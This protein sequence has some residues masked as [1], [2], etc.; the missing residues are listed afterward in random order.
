[1]TRSP[2]TVAASTRRRRLG[3]GIALLGSALAATWYGWQTWSMPAPPP[4]DLTGVDPE[5][6]QA[7][8][9]AVAEVRQTP[10]DAL[11]WGRLGMILTGN[12]F[13]NAALSCFAEAE[14]LEPDNPRWPYFQGFIGQAHDRPESLAKLRRAVQLCDESMSAPRLRLAETLWRLGQVESARGLFYEILRNDGAHARAHLGLARI[15]LQAMELAECRWHLD[16]ALGSPLTR[17]AARMLAVE[18]HERVG[19]HVA[20]LQA[21]AALIEL[22][23]DPDWPDEFLAEAARQKVGESARVEY[24]GQLLAQGRS[25]QGVRYLQ[26]L[27][28]DYPNSAPG[29]T[30]L[31]WAL[32]RVEQLGEAEQALRTAIRLDP[33]TSRARLYLAKVR[34][35]QG[36]RQETINLFREAIERKPN[37]FEAHFNLGLC[38]EETGDRP[39]AI[40][41]FRAAVQCQPLSAPAHARLG[42]L[43][44]PDNPAEARSHLE[45]ALALDPDHGRSR[46]LLA[47]LGPA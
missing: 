27:V 17:K 22:L 39:A 11:A 29:W 1:M 32:V 45:Q 35:Q 6:R 28:R 46:D 42:E 31:G 7:I 47:K 20:A 44:M 26:G 2:Q 43:L 25:A 21:Q 24:A 41:A 10:R 12:V 38:L 37:F 34:Y 4:L 23:D 14:R 16:R 15:H 33:G 5:V 19:D 36:D 40:A 9:G 13:Q 30:L 18:M 8:E 3:W